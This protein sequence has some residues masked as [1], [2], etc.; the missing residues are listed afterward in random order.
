[1]RTSDEI[2]MY[3]RERY[4]PDVSRT[5]ARLSELALSWTEYDIESDSAA[6]EDVEHLTGRRKVPTVVIGGRV[7]VEPS[8]EELDEALAAAGYELTTTVRV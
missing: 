5:R 1:M 6:A 7:L 4:C 2:V 3:A 8:N